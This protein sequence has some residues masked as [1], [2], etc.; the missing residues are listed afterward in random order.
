[1]KCEVVGDN[2]LLGDLAGRTGM[3]MMI[4]PA[5]PLGRLRGIPLIR[6]AD[7]SQI[8]VQSRRSLGAD[9]YMYPFYLTQFGRGRIMVFAFAHYQVPAVLNTAN[10]GRFYIHCVQWLAGKPLS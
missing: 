2:P 8:T 7:M 6:V 10:H 9:M 3:T 4:E 5:G 1:V